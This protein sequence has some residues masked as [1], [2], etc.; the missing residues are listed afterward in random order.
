[1]KV[2]FISRKH[3][4]SRSI[5]LSRWSRA[6]LSLCC[7]GLPLGLAASGYIAGQESGA[8]ALRGE[9]LDAS[10]DDLQQ[11]S[12][13]VSDQDGATERQVQ[14]LTIN[15]A[16]L[17]ARMTRLDALGQHLTAMA[18]LEDGEF[19]FS[20]PPAVGG[21]Q[22][23]EPTTD[24][25][26]KRLDE[27]LDQFEAR[28]VNRERQLDILGSMLTN[29]KLDEQG[30]LSGLPVKIG[31]MSSSYG[32][33]KDP[34]N[35]KSSLHNGI[36][37]AGKSG[38]DVVAVASGVVTFTGRDSGYGNV[39]EIS[40]GDDYVTRYAHNKETLVHPGDVVRKGETIA[41]M[42]STGR[43]T[44]SHLHFEV[45]KNGR[46]VDPSSYVARTHP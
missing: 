41:L 5:E 20:Q 40:H 27:E 12:A 35:G 34:F 36:D 2:I 30:S 46:S 17:E 19:D 25:T 33:R 38:S 39:V 29:R 43:S 10:Q 22:V 16:E 44:G 32:W 21:P 15:L 37:F 28:L 13:S 23:T 14:A 31:Y 26:P 7:L 4:S 3:G 9:A 6:L 18:N 24:F 8:R 45:Y 11:Q 42:G 1:M